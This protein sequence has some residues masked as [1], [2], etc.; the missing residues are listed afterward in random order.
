MAQGLKGFWTPQNEKLIVGISTGIVGYSIVS[1]AFV[2]LPALP[3]FV[4][5]TIFGQI[6]LLTVAGAL[7]IYNLVMLYKNY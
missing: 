2:A 3:S 6:S 4:S 7:A 5:K 1:K